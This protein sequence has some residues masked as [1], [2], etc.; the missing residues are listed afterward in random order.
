MSGSA[1]INLATPWMAR[2][3]YELLVASRLVMGSIQS[4]VFPSLYVL[5][6]HWLTMT[7]A[8]I[9][10]P[11]LKLSIKCGTLLASIVS[12]L[13]NHWADVFYVQGAIF[14]VYAL[15][16][17]L[18]SSSDPAD[19]YWV[20]TEEVHHIKRKKP[21]ASQIEPRQPEQN[22]HPEKIQGQSETES[23]SKSTPWL[24]LLTS[25]SVLGLCLAKMTINCSADFIAIELP[26][27]LKFVH[28]AS[29]ETISTITSSIALVQIT[30]TIVF[31]WVAKVVLKRQPYGL[32]R[33]CLRRIFQGVANFGQFVCFM[34]ITLD[35]CNTVYVSIMLQLAA[36]TMMSLSGGEPMVP[37]ELSSE[38]L[39]TIVAISNSAAN[40]AGTSITIVTSAVL[41]DEGGNYK[42]WNTLMMLVAVTN[43]VGGLGFCTMV[44]SEPIDFNSKRRSG[45]NRE[46]DRDNCGDRRADIA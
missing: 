3:S 7:E 44:R 1:I 39:A 35:T 43:L 18:I 28:H 5:F 9:F 17:I 37:F 2:N 25:P 8:S 31:S 11:L 22:H 34:M 46:L 6:F 12:G 24:R 15:L 29:K 21:P 33:T 16:W 10:A 32:S 20:S 36:F 30:F 19:N 13:M 23:A 27:Y 26:S 40:L 42:R 14:V 45:K 41:G 4:C 38:Y